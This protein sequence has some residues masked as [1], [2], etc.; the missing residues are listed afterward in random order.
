MTQTAKIISLGCAKN[1]CDSQGIGGSLLASGWQLT[2]NTRRADAVIINTC[3]FIQDARDESRQTISRIISQSK[4]K[5]K[6]TQVVVAGCWAQDDPLKLK[7]EFPCV[8]AFVGT[9]NLAQISGIL[10]GPGKSLVVKGKP[11]GWLTWEGRKNLRAAGASAYMRISEGC[12][13]GC[14]FCTIP[15]LRGK[16]TSREMKDILMEAQVLDAAGI[17]EINLIGQDTTMYG[18]DLS[19]NN[20]LVSLLKKLLAYKSFAFIRIL[21]AYPEHVRDSLLRLIAAESSICKYLDMPLQHIATPILKSMGREQSEAGIR[22]L[23]DKIFK[24]I[25]DVHLRSSFI[26]GFP[27]ETENDFSRLLAFITEGHIT[28]GGVFAYS[29][30]AHTRAYAMKQQIPEKIKQERKRILLQ[31]QQKAVKQK[32]KERI[33]KIIDVLLIYVDTA[34]GIGRSQWEAPDVDGRIL[35]SGSGLKN[36]KTG[37]IV[38]VRITDFY[39]YDCYG[40]ILS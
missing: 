22:K 40:E 17:K 13:N 34:Y 2:D 1:L 4:S 21:Y 16:F 12:S 27:G 39:E 19:G 5:Q 32:N 30:E 8:K 15:R 29:R 28:H 10:Q 25:P 33:G 3:S 9:G 18:S 23:I 20:T 38:R 6:N 35:C 11:G 31:A 24:Y 14:S 37:D 36:K 7:K 26:V